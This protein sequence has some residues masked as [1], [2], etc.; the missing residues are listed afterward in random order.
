MDV[1]SAIMNDKSKRQYG[2][3]KSGA[4]TSSGLGATSTLAAA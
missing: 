4:A 1:M 3:A 2:S